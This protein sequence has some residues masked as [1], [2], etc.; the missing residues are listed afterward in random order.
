V[1]EEFGGI[2]VAGGGG[3]RRHLWLAEL[4][5]IECHQAEG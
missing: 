1:F 4:C 5:V 3:R 2:P